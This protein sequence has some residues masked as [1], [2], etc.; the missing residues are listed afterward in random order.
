MDFSFIGKGSAPRRKEKPGESQRTVTPSNEASQT[1][2]PNSTG[3][4]SLP[5]SSQAHAPSAA[6]TAGPSNAQTATGFLQT[7]SGAQRPLTNFERAF[8]P[9][10]QQSR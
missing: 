6:A 1:A 7:G 2:R 5:N 9:A 8:L 10:A 3:P 4:Q